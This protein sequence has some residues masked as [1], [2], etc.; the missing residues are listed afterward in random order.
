MS[1]PFVVVT[2]PVILSGGSQTRIVY[3]VNYLHVM[4]ATYRRSRGY[5]HSTHG[6][7][8]APAAAGA[9][10]DSRVGSGIVSPGPDATPPPRDEASGSPC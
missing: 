10:G 6:Q 3:C 2:A 7:H 5:D 1:L 4:G 8:Q 9:A